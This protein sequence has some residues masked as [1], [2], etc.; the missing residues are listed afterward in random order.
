MKSDRKNAF[1]RLLLGGMGVHGPVRGPR[2][3][4]PACGPGLPYALSG[5]L[6]DSTR[7]TT[8]DSKC[9]SLLSLISFFV[10]I[11]ALSV[12]VWGPQSTLQPRTF[13]SRWPWRVRPSLPVGPPA[14][15]SWLS[16]KPL[17]RSRFFRLVWQGQPQDTDGQ[18]QFS[19]Q[20]V[21]A[22]CKQT[23]LIQI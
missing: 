19:A 10:A 22:L 16:G 20:M 17:R 8:N 13:P 11:N 12:P 3:L 5:P 14:L 15:S 21:E 4:P 9:T 7:K 18:K 6:Q 1:T 2:R 23:R